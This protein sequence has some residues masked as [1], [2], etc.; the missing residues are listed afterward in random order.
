MQFDLEIEIRADFRDLSQLAVR[1]KDGNDALP[2]FPSSFE[3]FLAGFS[4]VGF[5]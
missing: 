1:G 2:R 3:Q 4:F 5:A